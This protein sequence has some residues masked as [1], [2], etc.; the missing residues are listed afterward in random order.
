M[1]DIKRFLDRRGKR[2][3]WT[4]RFVLVAL[5]VLAI[6]V[7]GWIGGAD[8]VTNIYTEIIGVVI[9]IGFTVVIVD[10]F[11]ERREREREQEQ[12]QREEE[13]QTAELKRRLIRE[14]GSRSND[15]A[16]TAVEWLREKNWLTGDKG[17]LKGA[18]LTNANL[19]GANLEDANLQQSNL[20]AAELQD[21][22]FYY[23]KLQGTVFLQANLQRTKFYKANLTR[24]VLINADLT[25]AS[26]LGADLTGA[27][28]V[29]AT[30]P[31]GEEYYE[32]MDLSKYREFE[33]DLLNQI[34]IIR[35]SDGLNPIT[36]VDDITDSLPMP[37][38]IPLW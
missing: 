9:S 28:F 23:A 29:G 16:T 17:L 4:A 15:L 19:K 26:L 24:A 31:D 33:E 22:E 7:L 1:N 32:G 5:I 18:K 6:F 38:P 35:I 2:F 8:Y 30:M 11:Y 25:G 10:R 14:A 12:A 27:V 20:M 37:A 13:R 34:N 3:W 21:A 36:G